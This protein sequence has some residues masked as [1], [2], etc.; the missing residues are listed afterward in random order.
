MR[1]PSELRDDKSFD[2]MVGRLVGAAEMMAHYMSLHGDD[3]ARGMAERVFGTISFFLE[4][5]ARLPE[6]RQLP[7]GT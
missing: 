2:Y 5:E 3:N 7:K 6:Q 1:N 4:P